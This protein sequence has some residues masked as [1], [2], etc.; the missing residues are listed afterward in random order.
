MSDLTREY[1]ILDLLLTNSPTLFDTVSIV[2]GI[3]DNE[4]VIAVV[5][6]RPTIQKMKPRTVRIYSRANW[7]GMRY[8]MLEFQ[9][10][11]LATCE[12]KIQSNYGRSLKVRL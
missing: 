2:P 8:D 9:L 12:G 11:F 1:N 6:L 7:E 5:K 3:S 10:S 4:I